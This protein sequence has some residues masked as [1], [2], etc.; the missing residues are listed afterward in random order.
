MTFNEAVDK[1]K[2][3][4]IVIDVEDASAF[5]LDKDGELIM[6]VIDEND[7]NIEWWPNELAYFEWDNVTSTLWEVREQ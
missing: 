3:G 5:K 2:A 7:G 6:G 4:A 1:I